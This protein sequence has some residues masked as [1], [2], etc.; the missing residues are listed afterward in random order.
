MEL[1]MLAI[2]VTTWR[3]RGMEIWRRAVGVQTPRHGGIELWRCAADQG[4]RGMEIRRSRALEVRCGR[5]EVDV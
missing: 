4:R 1:W 5:A 2:G 3:R